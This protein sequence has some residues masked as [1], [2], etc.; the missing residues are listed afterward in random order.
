MVRLVRV[1]L[2]VK[3]FKLKVLGCVLL[4]YVL[5]VM[6]VSSNVVGEFSSSSAVRLGANVEKTLSVTN[7]IPCPRGS[8]CCAWR[9]CVTVLD[10]IVP[11][12]RRKFI[13]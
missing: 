7:S 6:F 13:L 9:A 11:Q 10:R 2:Q 4:T 3:L 5:R 8:I 1:Q 12:D